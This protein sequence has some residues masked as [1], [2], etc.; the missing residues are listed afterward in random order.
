MLHFLSVFWGYG[1]KCG[2]LR[3]KKIAHFFQNMV[4]L[5]GT[6][7]DFLMFLLPCYHNVFSKLKKRGLTEKKGTRFLNLFFV[8]FAISHEKVLKKGGSKITKK[9]AWKWPCQYQRPAWYCGAKK[10][11]KKWRFK[12]MLHSVQWMICKA[13]P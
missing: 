13:L 4:G 6:F 8:T 12:V 5:V 10:L 3:L 7:W 11:K 9:S 1:N 2:N